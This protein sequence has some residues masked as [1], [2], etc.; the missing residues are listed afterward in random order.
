MFLDKQGERGFMSTNINYFNLTK[1]LIV[2][3]DF[4]SKKFALIS[5]KN[6]KINKSFV[7]KEKLFFIINSRLK[8]GF[9]LAGNNPNL[10]DW[11]SITEQDF[12]Q[13]AILAN[14][15]DKEKRQ[16]FYEWFFNT[17]KII[18]KG[19][20]ERKKIRTLF[21]IAT[22]V[23]IKL[24]KKYL[25]QAQPGE[26]ECIESVFREYEKVECIE[27]IE[28]K[29]EPY[30]N[31]LYLEADR[32]IASAI[33]TKPH[34]FGN[35]HLFFNFVY[36]CLINRFRD[37]IEKEIKRCMKEKSLDSSVS[38]EESQ[39]SEEQSESSL[40]DI[41]PDPR[42]SYLGQLLTDELK[43][44]VEEWIRGLQGDDRTIMERWKKYVK[45]GEKPDNSSSLHRWLSKEL[46]RSEE[47]IRRRVSEL[48]EQLGEFLRERGYTGPEDIRRH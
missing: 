19:I 25:S 30:R 15:P 11:D 44:L 24:R 2:C 20:N 7:L 13:K 10:V 36:T 40:G 3:S 31:E 27:D 33:I 45:Y 32:L 47:A 42:P 18:G 41:I 37:I 6:V 16:E 12:Q 4:F 38:E 8:G 43:E 14:S 26:L 46:G 23:I 1:D 29:N 21:F 9:M 48:K 22:D 34:K 35:K 28:E 5:R 39:N 17:Y